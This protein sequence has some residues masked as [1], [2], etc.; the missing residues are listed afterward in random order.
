MRK[1]NIE[2]IGIVVNEPVAMANWY[3]DVLG[4]NIKF[5]YEE[6]G[7]GGAFVSDNAGGV[8]LEFAKLPEVSSLADKTDHYMQ[9]HIALISEDPERDMEYL[10]Q[11]G[12]MFV[13]KCP[14]SN[15][16]ECII[17]AKDPWGNILQLVK[18]V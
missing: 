13:A 1:F 15:P 11:N 6:S 7:K 10:A 17:V 3:K 8:M 4:F 9:L 5:A 14:V 2:H 12:A 18:R 16:A